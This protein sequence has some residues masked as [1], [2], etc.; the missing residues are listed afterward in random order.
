LHPKK[1]NRQFIEDI[2]MA[3]K[4]IRYS[5]MINFSPNKILKNQDATVFSLGE[6]KGKAPCKIEDEEM[7]SLK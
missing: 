1:T 2:L 6:K 5:L 7:P 4:Q 3:N